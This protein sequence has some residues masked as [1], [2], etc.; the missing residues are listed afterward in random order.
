M[1][2]I[3]YFSK[4]Q[5]EESISLRKDS[6]EK[7]YATFKAG[8]SEKGIR[9]LLFV[10]DD[11]GAKREIEAGENAVLTINFPDPENVMIFCMGALAD[12]SS[13]IIPG[14]VDGTY[15]FEKKFCEFGDH[16]LLITN[17]REFSNRINRSLKMEENAFGSSFFEGGYGLVDYVELDGHSGNV[18]LFRK[19][20]SYSWQREFRISFGINNEALNERGAYEFD[21]GSITDI[22]QIIKLQSLIDEPLSIKRTLLKKVDGEYVEIDG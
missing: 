16:I 19:G 20:I 17:P 3:E 5:G 8:K 11:N 1:N 2:S 22:S 10:V 12:D 13:G 21:V 18:G 4:L 15:E 9:K 6:L 7:V 14:E